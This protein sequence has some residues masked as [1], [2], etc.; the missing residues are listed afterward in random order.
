MGRMFNEVTGETEQVAYKVVKGDDGTA[1]VQID[2]RKYAPQRNFSN[3]AS[4]NEANC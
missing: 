4:K 3:G 1:R 2:D